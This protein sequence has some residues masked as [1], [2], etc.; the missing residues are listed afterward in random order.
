[1][2]FGFPTKRAPQLGQNPRLTNCPLS[3]LVSKYFISPV[4]FKAAA[5]TARAE[6]KAPPPHFWQSRQ[7][8]LPVI[9]GA[10]EHS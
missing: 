5:G 10:A 4:I 6:E 2:A 3:P 8:Q 1:L 9:S 7:W